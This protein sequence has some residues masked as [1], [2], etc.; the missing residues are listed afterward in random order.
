M[1]HFVP[2]RRLHLLHLHP[3][4]IFQHEVARLGDLFHFA[5]DDCT[6]M[7]TYSKQSTSDLEILQSLNQIGMNC[8]DVLIKTKITNMVNTYFLFLKYK[9]HTEQMRRTANAAAIAMPI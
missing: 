7:S 3:Y 5:Q 4:H 9:K 1:H 2:L 6:C 8:F